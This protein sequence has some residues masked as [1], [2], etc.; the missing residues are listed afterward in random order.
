MFQQTQGL[1]TGS[2]SSVS[3]RTFEQDNVHAHKHG[4]TVWVTSD[5]RAAVMTVAATCNGGVRSQNTKTRCI[6]TRCLLTAESGVGT[7]LKPLPEQ[8]ALLLPLLLPLFLKLSSYN[9][10]I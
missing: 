5:S 9:T 7:Y 2:A 4:H 3:Y 1:S 8:R 6:S 10:T